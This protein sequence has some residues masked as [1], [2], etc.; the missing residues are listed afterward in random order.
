MDLPGHASSHEPP[1]VL[2]RQRDGEMCKPSAS[3][4]PGTP[5]CGGLE[6]DRKASG[7]AV[8]GDLTPTSSASPAFPASPASLFLLH[9]SSAMVGHHV[10]SPNVSCGGGRH[11]T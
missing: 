7:V 3:W 8:F 2:C 11:V 9:P 6:V 10:H 4:Y 1:S 5:R